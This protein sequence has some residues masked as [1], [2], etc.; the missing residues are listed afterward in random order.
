MTTSSLVTKCSGTH[1][2]VDSFVVM[3]RL[4]VGR[5]EH[6]FELG[7]FERAAEGGFTSRDMSL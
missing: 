3:V 6:Y 1:C 2:Q 7:Y 4:E 5:S